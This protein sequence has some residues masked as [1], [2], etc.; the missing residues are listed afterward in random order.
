M[1]SRNVSILIKPI[2][3]SKQNL[4]SPSHNRSYSQSAFCVPVSPFEYLFGCPCATVPFAFVLV[5]LVSS[6]LSHKNKETLGS[7]LGLR[8]SLTWKFKDR[9]VFSCAV[10]QCFI[11]LSTTPTLWCFHSQGT[12]QSSA[13]HDFYLASYFTEFI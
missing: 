3:S 9:V 11:L 12:S 10:I 4:F 6:I 5:I 2:F 1:N 7:F 8:P 13:H